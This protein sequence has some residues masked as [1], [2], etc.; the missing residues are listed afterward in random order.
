MFPQL[1][2]PNKGFATLI[3]HKVSLSNMV[4][5]MVTELSTSSK[6]FITLVTGKVLHVS[7]LDMSFQTPLVKIDFPTDITRHPKGG[8]SFFKVRSDVNNISC[9]FF[10]TYST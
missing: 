5:L 7:V 4:F 2:L 1:M 8:V 3:T 6:Y 9:Y 10:K